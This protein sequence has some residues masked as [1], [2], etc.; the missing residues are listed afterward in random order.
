MDGQDTLGLGGSTF[1]TKQSH[2]QLPR[3]DQADNRNGQSGL[4]GTVGT[5]P[6]AA[7]A[8][9]QLVAAIEDICVAVPDFLSQ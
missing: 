8:P 9:L 2:K 3:G 4:A 7:T 5:C 6:K 1:Q